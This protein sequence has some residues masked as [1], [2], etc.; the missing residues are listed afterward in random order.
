VSEGVGDTREERRRE[1]KFITKKMRDDK[2]VEE[3]GKSTDTQRIL[4][5]SLSLSVCV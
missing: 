5:L 4:S 3:R 2:R 1:G